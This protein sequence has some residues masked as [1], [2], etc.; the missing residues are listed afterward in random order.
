MRATTS[1]LSTP[2]LK[3]YRVGVYGLACLGQGSILGFPKPFT[4]KQDPAVQG[5]TM[6]QLVWPKAQTA[7][8][9]TKPGS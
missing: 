6:G 1:G 8:L 7:N 3:R 5:S 9:P 2:L 4:A